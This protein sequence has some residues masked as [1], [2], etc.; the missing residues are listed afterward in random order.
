MEGGNTANNTSSNTSFVSSNSQS[1]R[2]DHRGVRGQGLGPAQGQGLGPAQGQ[3]LGGAG[4]AEKRRKGKGMRGPNT[5]TNTAG[6]VGGV[7]GMGGVQS[8]PVSLSPLAN[9][10]VQASLQP[11]NLLLDGIPGSHPAYRIISF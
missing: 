3:G 1:T 9:A 6:G 7:G 8:S 5:N 11:L 2:K 4:S 10:T